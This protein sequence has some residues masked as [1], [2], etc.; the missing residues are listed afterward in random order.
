[1][2][3]A[4]NPRAQP[5]RGFM[6]SSLEQL[7]STRSPS[8]P[9]TTLL[10]VLLDKLPE[11][12]VTFLLGPLKTAVEKVFPKDGAGHTSLLSCSPHFSPSFA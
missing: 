11:T 7:T 9:T 5:I 1:M 6:V 4:K 12:S 10:F 2:S 8:D 3:L